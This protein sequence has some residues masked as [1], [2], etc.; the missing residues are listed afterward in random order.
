MFQ[1]TRLWSGLT[2]IMA[3]LLVVVFVGGQIANDNAQLI[4]SALNIETTKIIKAE[5][6]STQDTMYY[7]TSVGDKTFTA[8]NFEN[9]VAMTLEQNKNEMREGAALLKNDNNAWL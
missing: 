5:G 1:K 4:N 6:G 8:A 9:L 3:I 7:K 2:A